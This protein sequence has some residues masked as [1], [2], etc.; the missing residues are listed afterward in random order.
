MA[1]TTTPPS[2]TAVA[3]R[4]PAFC[5]QHGIAR[6]EVFGS[7]AR[8]AATESSDVDLMITFRPEIHPG[9]EFFSMQDQ[10]EALLGCKGDLVTRR[11]VERSENPIRQRSIPETDAEIYA[12]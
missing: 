3:Q 8:G 11:A 7:L 5:Q 10:L 12:G 4:Q 6:V 2:L 1:S 9:L